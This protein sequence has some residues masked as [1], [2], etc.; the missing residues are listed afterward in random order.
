MTGR[1]VTMVFALWPGVATAQQQPTP[2]QMKAMM[3][4]MKAGPEHRT[5]AALHRRMK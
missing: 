1:I 3:E 2:E 5:L 4:Q